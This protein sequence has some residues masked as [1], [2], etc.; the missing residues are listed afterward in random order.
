MSQEKEN[1]KKSVEQHEAAP[2]D[3]AQP[4]AYEIGSKDRTQMLVYPEYLEQYA[5]DEERALPRVALYTAQPIKT[6]SVCS[7]KDWLAGEC[8]TCGKTAEEL[9]DGAIPP[10]ANCQFRVCDLPGQ[11]RAEGACHHPKPSAPLEGT[12]NGADERAAWD[13]A[14]ES[15]AVAMAGFSNRSGNRDFNAAISVLDAITEPGL[16]L[17]WLRTARAPR[18]EVAG[19]VAIDM[20]LFCPRCGEQHIDAPE[21]ADADVDVD[22]TV[23]SATGEWTN[24]PHRSHLCHMCGT[25]WRPADVPTNGVASIE[26]RGKADTWTSADAAAARP[27]DDELWDQALR[28]RDEYHETADKLA[29]AIAKHFGVDIGE[30]SNL[31]CPWDEALEAIENAAPP[32]QVAARQGLMDETAAVLRLCVSEL[33]GWMKDHGQDIRSQ[34]AIK[35]ARAL[36]DG[37]KQ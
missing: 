36:L 15:L 27:S 31:N 3:D 23:I 22:G 2:A 33:R 8:L 26:T 29:A 17:S 7:H 25:I 35:R 20:L 1:A 28:E 34:E 9:L 30:H 13:N 12:G 4:Y 18:T 11:C 10:F 21:P 5:T 16:P 32:A 19:A 6:V 14:R 37:D 24:P